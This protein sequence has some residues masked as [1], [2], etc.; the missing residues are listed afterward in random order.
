MKR[1]GLVCAGLLSVV[2]SGSAISLDAL[3]AS[4][5]AQP[6]AQAAS[7]DDSTLTSEVSFR[8]WQQG[9]PTHWRA[10]LLKP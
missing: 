1:F 2:F 10:Y 8:R 4:C 6:A 7:P 3:R 9:Q 5:A